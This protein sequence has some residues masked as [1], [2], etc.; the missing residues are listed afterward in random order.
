[1]TDLG[2][3]LLQEPPTP[4]II[5]AIENQPSA[6]MEKDG[7]IKLDVNFPGQVHT[8]IDGGLSWAKQN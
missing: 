3:K 5:D 2:I 7:S 1:M 6:C 8:S 4:E